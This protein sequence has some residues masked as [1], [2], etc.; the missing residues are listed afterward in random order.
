[1]FD[2]IRDN[3]ICSITQI[4]VEEIEK[5]NILRCSLKAMKISC[6]DV[7]RKIGNDVEVFVDGNR[8]IPQFKYNQKILVKGDGRSAV[9]AAASILAKVSRDNI[10]KKYAIK[11]PRY[12]FENNKGYGTQKHINAILQ[13][14]VTPI[15]RQ[16]FLKKIYERENEKQLT[17]NL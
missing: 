13:Y 12:D 15:H 8:K 14:G 2:L 11:Y 5:E 10:M 9:I 16:S 4:S 6:E 3:S 1:M 17:L 7:I